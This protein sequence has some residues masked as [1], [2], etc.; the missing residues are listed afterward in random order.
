MVGFDYNVAASPF[1]NHGMMLLGLNNGR[2]FS[3][4]HFSRRIT[5]CWTTMSGVQSSGKYMANAP[6]MV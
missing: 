2:S 5:L 3:I 1:P 4:I 6:K